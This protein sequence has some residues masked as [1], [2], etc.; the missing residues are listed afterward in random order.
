MPPIYPQ[1]KYTNLFDVATSALCT[2]NYRLNTFY[3]EGEPP[4]VKAMGD[5]LKESFLRSRRPSI[6]QALTYSS[7]AKYAEDMEIMN[8]VC[9]FNLK[10]YCR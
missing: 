7:N 3:T 1:L 9:P 4:F 5:F 6:V 10:L 2:F 8:A